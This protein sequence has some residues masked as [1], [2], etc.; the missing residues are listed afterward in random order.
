V[1]AQSGSALVQ[2]HRP[3]MSAIT[4]LSKWAAGGNETQR[5]FRFRFRLA[6]G[7]PLPTFSRWE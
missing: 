5:T 2:Y 1:K 4:Q 7:C 6:F 3:E